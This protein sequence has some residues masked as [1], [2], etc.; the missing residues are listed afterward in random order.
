[1]KKNN[2]RGQFYLIA[3]IIIVGLVVALS[4]ALNSAT[5]TNSHDAEEIS[6]ELSIESENVLDYDTVNSANEFENFAKD[7]SAYVGEDKSIYF[8]IVNGSSK[9]AYKY[10]NGIKV[11]LTD[12]LVVNSDNIIFTLD[13][14]D[15][16]FKLEKGKNFYFIIIQDKGGERYVFTG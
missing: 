12:D 4:A 7:Y 10:S 8:I 16:D 15:Y 3:T 9:E 11:D 2:K 13:K 5:K 1:M 6:K 14:K